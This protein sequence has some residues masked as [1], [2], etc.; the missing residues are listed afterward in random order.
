MS[1]KQALQSTGQEVFPRSWG[2]YWAVA[3]VTFLEVIRDKLLYN[4]V[5]VSVLLFAVGVLVSKL[6]V[7]MSAER[8]ILD[9]GLS[10]MRLSGSIIAILVGSVL[11]ARELER[12][13]IHVALC[14]PI[15]QAQFVVGKYL[16]IVMVLLLN[17]F[18]SAVAE[19]CLLIL[20]ND[21]HEPVM[22]AT[23]GWAM[24]F[25]LVESWLMASVAVFFSSFTTTSL[26][27]IFCIG[28][29]GVG[30]NISEMR[31]VA[32]QSAVPWQGALL[33]G[34]ARCLPNLE[35]FNFGNKVTY[36]LPVPWQFI[37]Y[38]LAYACV[39]ITLFLVLSGFLLR[40]KEL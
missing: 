8:V 33:D 26:S 38:G 39:L 34:L 36:S 16:G 18:L 35:V 9:F 21:T 29:Y 10:A 12:R 13:T 31:L 28:L 37:G 22:N 24:I 1:E 6:A 40:F 20:F 5:V 15:T 4:S 11:I 25:A 14:H 27:I 7:V 19:F 23:L 2:V 17:W 32:H 30:Q 3:K